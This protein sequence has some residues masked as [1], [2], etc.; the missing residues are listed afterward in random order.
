MNQLVNI[1]NNVFKIDAL[2]DNQKEIINA[3]MNGDDVLVLL[4][5]GAGK[6]LTFQLPIVTM[7]KKAIVISPL[8]AL[9]EDQVI[10]LK[11]K[12]IKACC[13]H[14]Y[15]ETEDRQIILRQLNQ[16]DLI[17]C[18]PEWLS[19]NGMALLKHFPCEIVVID[20]AHCISEW[21]YEFRPSY[22]QVD[23]IIKVFNAQV[24]A[25]TATANERVIHDIQQV[26]NKPLKVMDF[27]RQKENQFLSVIHCEHDAHKLETIH[28]IL[29]MAGPTII[30]F[31]SKKQVE[32]VYQWLQEQGFLVERYHAD[33]QYEERMS[34]QQRFMRD[35]IQVI[36]ATNAFGMGVNKSNIRTVIHYHMPKSLF[37]FIQEI[38]RAGRDGQ[39]SQAILFYCANDEMIAYRLNEMN[40]LDLSEI[41]MYFNGVEL[42]EDKHNLMDVLSEKYEQQTIIDKVKQHQL[43]KRLAIHQ[44]LEYINEQ[45][46]YNAKL[47]ALN[48]ISETTSEI[49]CTEKQL[50]S[51]CKKTPYLTFESLSY[52]HHIKDGKTL[53]NQLFNELYDFT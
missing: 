4:P 47:N 13:I 7:E 37:Q 31:S 34:V 9:M 53:L 41:Q 50:C 12:K 29:K 35:E 20:E 42:A 28:E 33:M 22:L 21:G 45:S 10:Q 23:K 40:E 38:G 52:Q 14:S 49:E 1:L 19:I 27:L 46:C 44:M 48:M 24:I 3:V 15:L 51:H 18:S 16:Y 17:Y 43:S 32:T 2:R 6:S 39:L 26:V 25:L 36:C 8:I 5:T 11:S 30:Y